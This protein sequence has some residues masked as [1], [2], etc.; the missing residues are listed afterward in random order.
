MRGRFSVRMLRRG[1]GPAVLC[2]GVALVVPFAWSA[3]ITN[4][5]IISPATTISPGTSSVSVNPD[6]FLG[7]IVCG[8]QPGMM[9]SYVATVTDVLHACNTGADCRLGTC[10]GATPLAAGHCSDSFTLPSSPPTSCA[11]STFFEFISIGDGYTAV[12][13]GY[14]Q[15][16]DEL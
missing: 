3:C 16:A 4:P 9:Q 13:D 6:D 8:N 14:T 7:P 5:V 11:E 1:L 2:Y 15:P 10:V 12:V